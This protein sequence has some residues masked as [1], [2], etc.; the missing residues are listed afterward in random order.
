MNKTKNKKEIKLYN[1]ILPIWILIAFPVV[2]IYTIP[3]NFIVDSIVFL[4]TLKFLNIE[5]KK[6]I[7]K[8]SIMKIVIFGFLS[9]IIA[10][11]AL[12]FSL[13]GLTA[14]SRNSKILQGL[15]KNK[16]FIDYFEFAFYNPTKNLPSF[17]L[18]FAAIVIAGILIYIFNSK[19]SFT[20]TDLTKILKKKIALSLAI[21]TAPYFFLLSLEFCNKFFNIY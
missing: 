13:M 20:K 8:K 2:W 16:P 15:F 4:F 11:I 10:G 14:I 7:Y 9:D 17:L 6:E 21:F 5:N 19:Y 3:A 18:V 12:L 1:L